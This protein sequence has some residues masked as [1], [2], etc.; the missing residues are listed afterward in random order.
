MGTR[1]SL[2]FVL[3]LL[4]ACGQESVTSSQQS[5]PVDAQADVAALSESERLNLWFDERN[6]ELLAFSPL[7]LTM[8]GRKEKYDEIDDVSEAAE[9]EQ[10]Q[11]RAQTVEDLQANFDYDSLT[12]DARISYDIWVNQYEMAAAMAPFQRHAYIFEQMNGS[13]AGLPNIL[14]NATPPTP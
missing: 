6:E 3:L 4:S 1:I 12:A 11:W 14:I 7:T 5:M 8:L 2:S 9:Q 13:H 10:L